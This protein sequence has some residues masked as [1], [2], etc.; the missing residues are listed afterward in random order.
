FC[1]PGFILSAKALLD[2]TP[3]PNLDEIKKS[4]DGHICRCGGYLKIFEAIKQVGESNPK[5]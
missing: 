2:K 1:A 4:L 5:Q 3:H